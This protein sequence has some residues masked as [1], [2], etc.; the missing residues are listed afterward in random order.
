M[1][2]ST[3][4]NTHPSLIWVF[5][6]TVILMLLLDL[7]IFNRKAHEVS[8]KEA[9]VW[10]VV[11]ISLSMLFS[12]FVYWI[13]QSD[14]HQM[15]IEKLT[16]FQTAYWIEKA[17][18]V[19]NLFI[20]II[21]FKFFKVPNHLQHKVLFWGI[22]GA[23]VFR[24]IFIFTGKQIIDI[25]YLPA[26]Q[27]LGKMVRINAVLFI[28]GIF[29]LILGIKSWGA[30]EA[31]E[32]K[33]FTQN[34]GAKL[35]QKFWKV[36]DGFE[37]GKFFTKKNGVRM[38]TPL[39]LVLAVI[40]STDLIFAIDSIP[41]IFAVS[42]DPFILYASNIFAILGLRS[43]FFLL[44]NFIHMFSKLSYGLAVILS[45]IGIKMLIAPWIHISSVHS[46]IVVGSVLILATLASVC[47]PSKN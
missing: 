3:V 19:D 22:I 20:F 13:F 29:L 38:A 46:L 39:L 37:D 21:V 4:F 44:S 28:F 12:G 43:L 6:I 17:L 2:H 7:G 33:D 1:Q 30:D 9:L 47:F 31:N 36:S 35:I 16:Q 10:S 40:E 23:L 34:S 27:I 14:G 45:F 24:A 42:D 26:W 25:T 5:A 32:D 15:A 18:S 41:A 11:W 8:S